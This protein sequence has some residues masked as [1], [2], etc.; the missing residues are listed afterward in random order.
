MDRGSNHRKAWGR[1]KGSTA[2][3]H[4]RRGPGFASG[5]GEVPT[6]PRRL[7]PATGRT[8]AGHY[9]CSSF[10][11]G[12]G[13]SLD[14]LGGSSWGGAGGAGGL[15]GP[16][17][18]ARALTISDFLWRSAIWT[19][20]MPALFLAALSA[21][22]SRSR[23]TILTCPSFTARCSGVSPS[24]FCTLTTAP[25]R[26]RTM[27]QSTCPPPA[28]NMSGVFPRAVFGSTGA[29]CWRRALTTSTCPCTLTAACS[30]VRPTWSVASCCPSPPLSA[31]L[32]G[33]SSWHMEHS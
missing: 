9:G 21:P 2:G 5:R 22:L 6:L 17:C 8:T 11:G 33:V 24:E 13:L 27:P 1:P 4:R 15:A 28:A 29:L 10:S 26:M 14:A 19:G 31:S 25:A 23:L 3:S 7:T 30:A 16:S 20:V 18:M 12:W 32:M